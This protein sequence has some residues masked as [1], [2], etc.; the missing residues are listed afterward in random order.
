MEN[1]QTGDRAMV[2]LLV[3]GWWEANDH[4]NAAYFVTCGLPEGHPLAGCWNSPEELI[5]AGLALGFEVE[6]EQ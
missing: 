4:T 2:K 3:E 6:V 5:K 1:K